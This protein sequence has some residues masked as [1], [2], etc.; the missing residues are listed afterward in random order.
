MRL[1]TSLGTAVLLLGCQQAPSPSPL[2]NFDEQLY[3]QDLKTLSSDAFEGRAP[4]THGEQMTLD[5]LSNA[6]KE[7]GLTP[8]VDG[9]Y[10]QK[11][12]MVNYEADEQQQVTLAGLPLQYRKDIVLNAHNKVD[13]V[14]IENAPLVFVGYGINAPEYQWNDYQG[15]DMHGKIAIIMINDPGFAQPESGKFNGKAMT[16]YGRWTYKY[17]E[18]SRQGALGAIIIHDTAP[19][20]YPWSVV[21]HSWTGPQQDLVTKQ[22]DYRVA[23]EGWMTR[24]AAQKVFAASGLTLDTAMKRAAHKAI[25]LPLEQ[26]ASIAFRN[27]VYYADSYNVVATLEGTSAKDEHILLTGH[28]DHLGKDDNLEGDQIFNGAMDN[29]TGVAGILAIARQLNDAAK[30]GK[31]LK[32]SVTFVVTTG[33]EQGLLGSRYYAD[34][35]IYPLAQTVGVFNLDSTN[36]YGRTKDVTIVG[37]GKSELE[38]YIEQAAKMLGREAKPESHPEAG[39]YF[40]SDHFSFAKLGVP[41]V[42]VAGG[43]EPIDATTAA[44][45]ERMQQTMNGC[46]HNTCDE[47]HEDWDLSGTLDDLQ[48]HYQAIRALGDSDAKPGYYQGTEFYSLRPASGIKL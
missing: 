35:P 34:N 17:E 14:A 38:Q 44:Y 22:D 19:A 12:L 48:L 32:R 6:F 28:W 13:H 40:R 37:K 39:G 47:Y 3:R 8:T 20:S 41:A 1:L 46:Y 10:L 25:Q 7:M 24:D 5:Y 33:E 9:S 23:V 15:L 16:Y 29:A 42:Y 21:E 4:M 18:A 30:A 11:V 26:T 2:A 43:S 27:S 36:I 31:P 45:K